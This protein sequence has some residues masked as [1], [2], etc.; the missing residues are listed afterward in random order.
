MDLTRNVKASSLT[1]KEKVIIKNKKIYTG[2][3]NNVK[4]TI[5]P[6]ESTDSM[7]S[8]SNYQW[9]FSQN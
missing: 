4:I 1:K 8:L 6:K 9:H 3:I 2:R 5:L 7:H